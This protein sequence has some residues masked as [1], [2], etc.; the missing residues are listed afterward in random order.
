MTLEE[1]TNGIGREVMVY[2]QSKTQS[3]NWKPFINSVY[4]IKEI[5]DGLVCVSADHQVS[6]WAPGEL[7]RWDANDIY[8]VSPLYDINTII[9]NLNILEKKYDRGTI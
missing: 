4:T 3:G 9:N 6:S 7:M 5:D 2:D 1:A 8:F